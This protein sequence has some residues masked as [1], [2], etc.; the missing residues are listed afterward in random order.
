MGAGEGSWETNS[1]T[2]NKEWKTEEGNGEQSGTKKLLAAM[3]FSLY[4]N[5]YT[6]MGCLCPSAIIFNLRKLKTIYQVHNCCVEQACKNGMSTEVCEKQFSEA[7]CMYWEGSIYKTLI[8]AIAVMLTKYISERVVAVVLEGAL[9]SCVLS[10]LEL[11]NIPS[12]IKSVTS[13]WNML[14][15]TFDEPMT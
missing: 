1:Q 9:T 5:I 12:L 15:I 3:H 11:A 14:D 8:K 13:T 7:S 10:L 6:A 4:E 2:G